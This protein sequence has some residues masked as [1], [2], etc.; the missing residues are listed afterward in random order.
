MAIQAHT[1]IVM[2]ALAAEGLRALELKGPGLAERAHGDLG[3]RSSGDI[4]VLVHRRD[5]FAAVDLLRTMGYR[6]PQDPVDRHGVPLLHFSL[7]HA[8]RP[9]VEVHWRVHWYE[10]VFSADLLTRATP[11]QDGSLVPEPVD[12]AAALLL[13]YARDGFCGL[14]ILCDLTGWWERHHPNTDGRGLLD[15]HLAEYPELVPSWQTA[16]LVAEQVGGLPAGG[17]VSK[18]AEADR[19]TTLAARLASWSQRDDRDQLAAN[20]ALID[21]LFTPRSK[22]G[23]FVRRLL[24]PERP[25]AHVV[26]VSLRWIYALWRIRQGPWDQDLVDGTRRRAP[27]P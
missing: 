9:N 7:L 14:R 13:F 11:S 12:D 6:D 10:D 17:L 1:E 15:G 5:L 8:T 19:R 18:A 3:L 23:G 16:A 20:A 2:A 25:F 4:D 24:L 27:R 21:G 26:K 22:L